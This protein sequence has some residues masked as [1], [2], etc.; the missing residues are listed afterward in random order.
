MYFFLC[1]FYSSLILHIKK[2]TCTGCT[3]Q[4][5]SIGTS[6]FT[7]TEIRPI[8]MWSND[9]IVSSADH[10]SNFMKKFTF[11]SFHKKPIQHDSYGFFSHW[12]QTNLHL[13]NK[14]LLHQNNSFFRQPIRT[15][16]RNFVWYMNECNVSHVMVVWSCD[17][18][19]TWV[20]AV[21]IKTKPQIEYL[22][23][24]V[25]NSYLE[26]LE[27]FSP[28]LDFILAERAVQTA[29]H[30]GSKWFEVG[31]KLAH[32]WLKLVTSCY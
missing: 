3:V 15:E 32:Y 18:A 27:I 25:T 28:I 26:F 16:I 23:W 22:W 11:I 12:L 4:L 8:L 5:S 9:I 6:S 21:N 2:Y 10:N 20:L 29:V 19:F 31:P 14:W 24:F 17:I 30:C 7:L 13:L 1:T